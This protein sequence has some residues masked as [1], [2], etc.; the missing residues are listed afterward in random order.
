[1]NELKISVIVPVYNEEEV[2]EEFHKRLT[3][4]LE[5]IEIETEIIYVNDGSLDNTFE[6]LSSLKRKDERVAIL[7]LSRNFGKEAAM[8]AGIDYSCGDAV[9]IIDAD[10]Q[11]PPEIIPELVKEWKKGFDVVYARR[12]ERK[13]DPYLKKLTSKIFYLIFN[14]LAELKIPENTADY[15]LLSKRAVE[16]LKELRETNRFLKG[17][18][19]WIGFPQKEI[20][21]TREVRV[22]GKSKWNYFKLLN[23]ALDGFT[24]FTISPLRFAT[25]SGFI[26][27][28][29]TFIYGAIL[30]KKLIF[31]E[32]PK[33]YS[34]LTIIILFLSGIQLIT[35]GIIG[36]YLGK[37]FKEVKRRPL[38]FVKN[39]LPSQIRQKEQ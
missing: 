38:Y 21:F 13:G 19:F 28:I 26:V 6:L 10:L 3:K 29:A 15:R 39:Y 2:I 25:Y 16:A 7:D 33:E 31:S 11:D 30:L 23:L 9:I 22:A 20:L 37:I 5:N 14:K 24:S 4:T 1:M 35:L 17:L 36:E 27:T 32:V 34:Y 18:S 12:K 8:I